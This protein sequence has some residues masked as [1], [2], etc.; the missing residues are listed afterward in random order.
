MFS[1]TAKIYYVLVP[2]FVKNSFL[3]KIES[4][5]CIKNDKCKISSGKNLDTN[6]SSVCD[7]LR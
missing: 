7:E 4:L 3:P 1:L 5:S 6:D 2:I